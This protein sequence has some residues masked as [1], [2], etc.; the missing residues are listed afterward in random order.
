MPQHF[1]FG[2]YIIPNQTELLK[3]DNFECKQL[4]LDN[5]CDGLIIIASD[6]VAERLHQASDHYVWYNM[7][8]VLVDLL[9]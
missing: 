9:V 7:A 8:G 5:S 3:I 1:F 6:G 2:R 4:P